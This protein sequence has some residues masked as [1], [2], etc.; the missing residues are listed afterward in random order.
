M[1][2]MIITSSPNKDGLTAACG[3]AAKKGIEDA[4]GSVVTVNLNDFNISK[5]HACDDGWGPC[6]KEH[7]CQVEDD[8]Q[9]IYNMMK[10]ID[11]LVAITPVYFG[12]FSE[13]ARAFFDRLR[14]CEF[15]RTDKG[16]LEDKPVISVAAAGGSGN[17]T[18]SCLTTFEKLFTIIKAERFDY[19]GI[20]RFTREYKLKTIQAAAQEMTKKY[21]V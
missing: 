3:A 21:S 16:V 4:N 10:D 20:T 8:F 14:R 2:I 7:M 1:K 19:I 17:G 6:H 11:G 5:C 15:R 12:D 13:S 18:V 9:V